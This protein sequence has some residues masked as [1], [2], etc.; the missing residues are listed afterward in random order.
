MPDIYK[1]FP[2]EEIRHPNGN[3]FRSRGEARDHGFSDDQI[4]SIVEGEDTW[5][6]GPPHHYVNV[7]GF[8]ATKERHDGETYYHE[9]DWGVA[10]AIHE[11]EIA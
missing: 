4:W 10:R 5:S 8:V 2:F 6:Y 9:E 7:I 3:Y 1:E 11:D